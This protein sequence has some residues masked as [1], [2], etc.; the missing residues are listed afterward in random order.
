MMFM[1]GQS[2]PQNITALWIKNTPCANCSKALVEYFKNHDKPT[3][4]VGQIWH[5]SDRDDD[6][7]L[8]NLIKAGFKIKVWEK[9]HNIIHRSNTR[10]AEYLQRL[11]TQAK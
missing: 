1:K 11:E 7:G 5:L 3:L 8:V 6:Q 10:T 2:T 4:Y 9:L